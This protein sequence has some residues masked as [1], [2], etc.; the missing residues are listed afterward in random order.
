MKGATESG[1]RAPAARAKLDEAERE[2]ADLEASVAALA[3]DASEG[4]A[5]A[6]K[7]LGGH[8]SKIDQAARTVDELRRAVSLAERLDRQAA[9]TAAERMRGE[10]LA[11]FKKQLAARQKAMAA[12]LKAA[13]DMAAAYGEF[14]E[15]TLRAV[16][17]VPMSTVVPQMAIGP[18]GV[19]GAAFGPCERLV[20]AELYRLAPER[21]D[22]IGRFVLPF[23]KPS[24]EQ[25]R[26]EPTAIRPGIEELSA[27]N[28]AIVANISEQIDKL[29]D[30]AAR[31]AG[32]IPADRKDVVAA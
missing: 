29:N 21:Q 31:A 6:E 22:G 18:N 26:G 12:V 20:L 1:P 28:S 2:L 19:Y 27:A 10:Q 30:Q 9:V 16:V 3:L 24:S 25:T 11:E 15:A 7:A 4:K 17:A 5:G 8:R 32:M 13:A 14:S 23:A